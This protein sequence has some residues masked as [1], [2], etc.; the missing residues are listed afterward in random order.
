MLANR[1]EMHDDPII[2]AMTDKIS[3]L[4]GVVAAAII[5]VSI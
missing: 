3:W 2:F 1:N 5:A 4:T